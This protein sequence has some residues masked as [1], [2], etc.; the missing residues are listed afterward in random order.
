MCTAERAARRERLDHRDAVDPVRDPGVGVAG[1]DHVDRV[2]GQVVDHLEQLLVALA[3]RGVIG[4]AEVPAA[5]ADVHRRDDHARAL[6]PE[7]HRLLGDRVRRRRD[8]QAGEVHRHGLLRR[9]LGAD[10][11]DPDLDPGDLD[12]GRAR[13][14]GPQ[15]PRAGLVVDDVGGQE[16]EL[17]LADAGLERALR[18]VAGARRDRGALGAVVELVVADR[19]TCVAEVVV[20]PHHVG[21]LAEVGL[22]RALEQVAAVDQH[23]AAAIGRARRAQVRDEPGEHR[24]ALEGPVQIVGAD[25]R[26]RHRLAPGRRRRRGLVDGVPAAVAKRARGRRRGMRARD[27]DTGGDRNRSHAARTLPRIIRVVVID[28]VRVN[29]RR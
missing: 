24:Q 27:Q 5:R 2:P 10:A 1:D 20:R 15:D 19:R 16:R 12:Q 22:H 11:D 7:H 8:P 28:R 18:I 23:H 4:V 3:R 25:D 21:T 26:Q 6:G 29:N 14:V 17:R 9:R 13:R